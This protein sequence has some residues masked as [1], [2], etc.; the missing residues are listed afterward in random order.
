MSLFPSPHFPL[1]PG[2]MT[3]LR[4]PQF[5]LLPT[6][7]KA[8]DAERKEPGSIPRRGSAKSVSRPLE[9]KGRVKGG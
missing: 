4:V 3:W 1:T 5:V 9:L 2:H 6:L 8:R 7:G